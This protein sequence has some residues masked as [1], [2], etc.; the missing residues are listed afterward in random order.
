[1]VPFG[2]SVYFGLTSPMLRL[3]LLFVGYFIHILFPWHDHVFHEHSTD[4]FMV[5]ITEMLTH[6]RAIGTRLLFLLL[7]QPGYEAKV[8]PAYVRVYIII[9]V[10]LWAGSIIYSR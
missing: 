4:Y 7:L 6:A 9:F 3:D 1:M 8:N 5:N 2:G 10:V